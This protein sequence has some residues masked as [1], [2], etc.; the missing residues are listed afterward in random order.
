[1]TMSEAKSSSGYGLLSVSKISGGSRLSVE[2]SAH[3]SSR[4]A[5]IDEALRSLIVSPSYLQDTSLMV[6]R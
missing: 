1:M 3:K 6:Y 5:S 4:S 2:E